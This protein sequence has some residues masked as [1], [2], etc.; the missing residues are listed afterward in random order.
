MIQRLFLK[1]FLSIPSAI[2][3][4]KDLNL[5]IGPNNS[6][7]SNLLR[8]FEVLGSFFSEENVEFTSTWA[9]RLSFNRT[10][11]WVTLGVEGSE[12]GETWIYA[13]TF[14]PGKTQ[15]PEF[16]EIAGVPKPEFDSDLKLTDPEWLKTNF[17]RFQINCF[18][19]PF[20][21][22]ELFPRDYTYDSYSTFGV[23]Y[24]DNLDNPVSPIGKSDPLGHPHPSWKDFSF[25][26]ES[27]KKN[28]APIRIHYFFSRQFLRERE[29][30]FTDQLNADGSNL[31]PFLFYLDQNH[32]TLYKAILED[33]KWSLGDI[34]NVRTPL[35]K[36]N[37][38]T[39][40]FFDSNG[41][42]FSV[43]EVSE[44]VKYFLTF[45]SLVHQ[46]NPPKIL[47]IE[48]PENGIHPKRISQLLDY[49]RRLAEDK[50][51]R[52]ILTSHSPVVLDHFE[53]DPS[54]V[55]VFDREDGHSVIRNLK[56]EIL[57]IQEENYQAAT[58]ESSTG[59]ETLL[60]EKWLSGILN[61]VP[62]D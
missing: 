15:N 56:T 51:I 61:G 18:E 52:I 12:N 29:A 3:S 9:Q 60:G 49:L 17:S 21:F 14:R 44:G 30:K 32:P 2:I 58:G 24:F 43:E 39:L 48:E 37:K 46:P 40:K 4:L 16:V 7:K 34:E 53:P 25:I 5:L 31:V 33:L 50:G 54:T 35:D 6:G 41:S 47:L 42:D 8:A 57:E 26:Y 28:F 13:V 38:L 27:L 36:D 19:G 23:E 20:T 45:L 55:W 22:K 1:N 11:D 62:N 59:W 10:G